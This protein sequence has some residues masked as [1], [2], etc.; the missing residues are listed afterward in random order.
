MGVLLGL[1]AMLGFGLT[2]GI[3][4]ESVRRVGVPYT[5]FWKSGVTS[6]CLLASFLF[7]HRDVVEIRAS[8]L[9]FTLLLSFADFLGYSAFYRSLQQ[10][11][12]GVV[13]AAANVMI[14]LTAALLAWILYAETLSFIQWLAIGVSL[15]G[16]VCIS[17]NIR[18]L[19]QSDMLNLTSGVPLAL[20]A[21]L[22]WGPVAL[23]LKVPSSTLG[24]LITGSLLRAGISGW[25]LCRLTMG[26][27]T[28]VAAQRGSAFPRILIAGAVEAVGLW[29]M[30]TGLA[31]GSATIVITLSHLNPLI[32]T[33]Y[34]VFVYRERLTLT[35]SVAIG[36][37]LMGIVLLSF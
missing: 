9:A 5:M 16:L 32:S 25:S 23:L 14:I 28:P 18:D 26:R 2:D 20:L 15:M 17:V 3:V 4:R 31:A 11:K 6:L 8:L 22:V 21:G 13:S 1:T 36:L 10:G 35:Q 29:A 19:Q 30:I 27:R 12:L 7:F 33:L 24:P 37:I 34:G